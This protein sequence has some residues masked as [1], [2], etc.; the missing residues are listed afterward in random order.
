MYTELAHGE[1]PTIVRNDLSDVFCQGLNR[2]RAMETVLEKY[3]LPKRKDKSW[4]VIRSTLK[5]PWL[6]RIWVIQELVVSRNPV[7]MYR[8]RKVSWDEYI[9]ALHFI[10]RLQNEPAEHKGIRA[11][12]LEK[13]RNEYQSGVRPDLLEVVRRYRR[14]LATLPQDKIYGIQGI[15][16]GRLES[17]Y[18][19]K[20]DRLYTDFAFST[21]SKS[22]SLDILQDVS[23]NHKRNETLPSWVPDW[24]NREG[25][26]ADIT[27]G[28]AIF[29]PGSVKQNSKGDPCNEFDAACG[30]KYAPKRS[31]DGQCLV[32]S[33]C[34]IS[35]VS[36][37]EP[38]STA[39]WKEFK[40]Q[41]TED[42]K[43]NE[44]GSAQSQA[45]DTA[46]RWYALATSTNSSLVQL[47]HFFTQFRKTP[48][49]QLYF[50]RETQIQAL[51]YTLYSA[52]PPHDTATDGHMEIKARAMGFLLPIG[53][54]FQTPLHLLTKCL[55]PGIPKVMKF[56]TVFL[57]FSSF[58]ATLTGLMVTYVVVHWT[59]FFL[60]MPIFFAQFLAFRL[61]GISVGDG[62]IVHSW[63]VSG[64]R[65]WADFIGLE[66][67]SNMPIYSRINEAQNFHHEGLARSE[68]GLLA[69]VPCTTKVGDDIV[70]F[71]GG[72]TPFVIRQIDQGWKLIGRCYVHGIMY[73]AAFRLDLCKEIDLA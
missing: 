29:R 51:L 24:S 61:F 48:E 73:G 19:S 5:Q 35:K 47:F 37:V 63:L 16:S 66:G 64:E 4:E 68:N 45:F 13:Q 8:Q 44:R 42:S 34:F 49:R 72:K 7:V 32:L 41:E 39:I 43:P 22:A 36:E 25:V 27:S 9:T 54:L 58:I 2:E 1:E 71:Q 46:F 70:I 10:N 53:R 6:E 65:I 55:A 69:L 14:W 11:L 60:D 50:T 40:K 56:A 67:W 18:T 33:A 26:L 17:S 38:S 28:T 15:S 20:P 52:Y 12:I 21:I 23:C 57:L 31:K 62:F 30:T 3:G 59:A